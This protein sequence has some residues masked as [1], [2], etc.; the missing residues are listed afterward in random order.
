METLEI[1]ASGV[2]DGW[3]DMAIASIDGKLGDGFAAKNPALL[4]AFL[5]AC[6]AQALNGLVQDDIGAGLD[7]IGR[8]LGSV[9]AAIA[10]RE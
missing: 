8:A 4:G 2:V 7:E 1:T 9:A 5:N 3:L 10:A 6:A